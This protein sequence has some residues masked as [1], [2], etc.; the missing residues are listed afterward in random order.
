MGLMLSLANVV[1]QQLQKAS[2]DCCASRVAGP[3]L[4]IC[5]FYFSSC[6][7]QACVCGEGV[8][9][10]AVAPSRCLVEDYGDLGSSFFGSSSE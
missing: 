10:L 3:S 4:V 7:Q 2:M 9:D 6:V 1:H 5:R 8:L